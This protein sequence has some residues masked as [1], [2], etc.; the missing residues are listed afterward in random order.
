MSPPTV[1]I[2]GCGISGPVL[3]LLL[4]KKGYS[5][6]I[7]EKVR[8]LGDAGGS[9]VIQPNG[10]VLEPAVMN[11]LFINYRLASRFCHWLD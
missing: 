4:Q 5:P 11:G 9:L 7:V 6:V 8:V 3:A 1:I 10:S 2:V